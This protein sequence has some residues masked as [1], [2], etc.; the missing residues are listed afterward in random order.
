MTNLPAAD[1]PPRKD[2]DWSGKAVRF[3]LYGPAFIAA[4]WMIISAAFA[5]NQSPADIVADWWT[6]FQ[7]WR[8]VFA[9]LATIGWGFI[10]IHGVILAF[11]RS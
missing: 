9:A 8:L 10:I 1:Q 11:G 5:V 6:P 2:H 3:L 4:G 7:W